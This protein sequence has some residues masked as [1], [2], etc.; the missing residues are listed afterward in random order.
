MEVRQG[1]IDRNERYSRLTANGRKLI[2][3]NASPLT[4]RFIFTRLERQGKQLDPVR[5][6]VW[7]AP[8]VLRVDGLTH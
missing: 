1:K 2:A 7:N 5:G 6:L 8:R 4:A 3:G